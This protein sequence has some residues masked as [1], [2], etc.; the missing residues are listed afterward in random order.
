[1]V[2]YTEARSSK[3]DPAPGLVILCAMCFMTGLLLSHRWLGLCSLAI[4][5]LIGLFFLRIRPSD[6]LS[7]ISRAWLF[8]ELTFLIHWFVNSH[9]LVNNGG[10]LINYFSLDQG[11]IALS[12]TFRFALILAVMSALNRL[13]DMQRYGRSIGRILSRAPIG[14]RFLA[15]IELIATLALRM[16]PFIQNQFSKLGLALEARGE[17]YS[18]NNRGKLQK[19]RRLMFPLMV[20]SIRRADRTAIALQARGYDSMVQRTY[21][22]NSKMTFR[23][24][25]LASIFS[26]VAITTIWI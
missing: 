22:R 4:L 1:M 24:C 23:S 15:N 13:Y 9:Y 6:V 14:K 16:I 7:D 25:I 21:F 18:S 20:H 3:A 17:K 10:K 19:L 12:F 2:N 26:L 5:G 11:L 8:L